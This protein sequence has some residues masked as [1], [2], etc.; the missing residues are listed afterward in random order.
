VGGPRRAGG[1]R[2]ENEATTVVPSRSSIRPPAG[3]TTSASRS[4]RGKGLTAAS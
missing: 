1:V 4:T 3:V 2:G